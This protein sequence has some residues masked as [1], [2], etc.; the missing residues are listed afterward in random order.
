LG[1]R[2][3]GESTESEPEIRVLNPDDVGFWEEMNECREEM[4]EK[5][6]HMKR[7]SEERLELLK[8][9]RKLVKEMNEV[10][11]GGD[12]SKPSPGSSKV[13]KTSNKGAATK[14]SAMELPQYDY[15]NRDVNSLWA[16]LMRFE[17]IVQANG[18]ESE[19][20]RYQAFV[21]T[22]D[23]AGLSVVMLKGRRP[24][25]EMILDLIQSHYR[26]C[27]GHVDLVRST[28]YLKR[29]SRNS[30]TYQE[31]GLRLHS[32][33]RLVG[34]SPE[35]ARGYF[36]AGLQEK[37]KLLL[38]KSRI[39]EDSEWTIDSVIS[40]LTQVETGERAA[41]EEAKERSRGTRTVAMVPAALGQG[42]WECGASD[43]QRGVC[44][45]WKKKKI[46]DRNATRKSTQRKVSCYICG[47][48][49][50]S[51]NCALKGAADKR[52]LDCSN[53]GKGGHI[54]KACKKLK[55]RE[56]SKTDFPSRS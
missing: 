45:I 24:V 36:I 28:Q 18:W 42:C 48:N 26:R 39:T 20:H 2:K 41:Q 11:E 31:F 34:Q 43:H 13:Q 5:L 25:K 19:E 16:Y 22:M 9:I 32:Y 50:Y 44:E 29:D 12:T 56:A 21:R 35:T 27:Y 47:D 23:E 17:M 3:E 1:K 38:T 7:G 53:C 4:V 8:K 40:F 52:G 15:D 54:S 6:S 55:A 30:E 51:V 10:G 46:A 14:H 49:H 37:E 33:C